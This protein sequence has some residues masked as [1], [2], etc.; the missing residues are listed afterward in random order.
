MP[1]ELTRP[2]A[3]SRVDNSYHETMDRPL[4]LL[5]APLLLVLACGDS[6]GGTASST[7]QSP[8]GA[9]PD[10]GTTDTPTTSAPPTTDSVTTSSASASA[11]ATT[12]D[13]PD[14]TAATTDDPPDPT[15]GVC[16]PGSHKCEG[17]DV[18][19]CADDGGGWQDEG[20]CDPLL[21]ITCDKSLGLC[22]GPCAQLNGLSYIG[23]DY[24]PVTTQQTDFA[25]GGLNSFA[26]AVANTADSDAMV[27]V[28]RADELIAQVTVPALSVKLIK[29]PWVPELT[30]L[31]GPT[32]HAKQGAYHLRSNQPVTVYQFNPLNADTS[33]DASL[34]LPVNTWDNDYLTVAW[35]HWADY[36]YPG[37]YTVTAS[38]DNTIVKV[39]G[40]PGGTPVQKGGGIDAAGN[41][42]ALLNKGDV[43]SVVTAMGGDITGSLIH[44]DK[45]VQ[46]IAG[47]ECTQV[48]FA[49]TAC[50]HLEE[51]MFSIDVLANEY[52]VVP[53]V[54][55]PDSAKEKAIIVRIV[56]TADDT[57]L[58]FEPDQGAPTKLAKA[59]DFIELP[60]STN[61]YK[62]SANHKILVA[63]F[64]VGQDAGFGT[65]DPAMLLAVPSAQYRQEYLVYAQPFWKANWVDII[66]PKDAKLTVDGVPVDNLV[67]IASTDFS[68]AHVK[69]VNNADGNHT[70]KG[71]IEFGVGV[72]GVLDY[73][74]YWYPGGLDL[75]FIPPN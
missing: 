15:E 75:A 31:S 46:V 42:M 45:P 4:S 65:S 68:L 52:I 38:Q 6:G 57:D 9:L 40:P 16:V 5:A 48:P 59:G 37:F 3:I 19:V 36:N 2:A 41:G 71:D 69:L 25:L 72:Y 53:P 56:T 17:Q 60:Q 24:W 43:L 35:P 18:K 21:G 74:S 64:M 54:Q 30:N 20:T 70:L 61:K 14:P 44:A 29:L 62:V 58:T 13:P 22:T 10:T 63:Q 49:V 50:D 7:T 67:P 55:V 51:T 28:H 32:K 27:A 33:N 34:L 23:C 12:G 66:A 1:R 11:T 39:Q 73:G 8:T 47:H 26:V